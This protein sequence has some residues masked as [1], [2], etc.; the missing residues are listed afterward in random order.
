MT[1]KIT[2]TDLQTI[3]DKELTSLPETHQPSKS[4]VDALLIYAA[5]TQVAYHHDIECRFSLN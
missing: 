2:Q 3:T 1:G 5:T 4:I